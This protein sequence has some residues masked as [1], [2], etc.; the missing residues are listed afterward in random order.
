VLDDARI[1]TKALMRKQKTH[2][3]FYPIH[4]VYPGLK[5]FLARMNTINRIK[6]Q[7]NETSL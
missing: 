5:I 1:K 7:N 6:K 2:L 4:P 3:G